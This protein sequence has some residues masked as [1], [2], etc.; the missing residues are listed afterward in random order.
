MAG[1]VKGA[2]DDLTDIASQQHER[3]ASSMPVVTIHE[4]TAPPT[5]NNE[6]A[7]DEEEATEDNDNTTNNEEAVP[8]VNSLGNTEYRL[9]AEN[10]HDSA[11]ARRSRATSRHMDRLFTACTVCYVISLMAIGG[12]V[13]ASIRYFPKVPQYNI[14]NDSVA[15]KSLVDSMTS[16]KVDADIEILM[17]IM[18]PNHFDVA[19]DM[20]RGSFSHDGAFVGTFEIPPAQVKAMSITDL[21]ILAKFTPEK[22]EALSLTAEYYRGTLALDIDS[23]ASIRVPALA[24]YSYQAKVTNMRVHVNDPTMM[25]RHLCACPQWKDDRNKTIAIE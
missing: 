1:G 6:E 25:D 3:N 16:M 2:Y 21:T 13:L 12:F 7:H 14:C 9:M 19:L 22:W 4:T 8:L 17:S 23:Q 20:G 24:N 5:A 11:P 10:G 18:N 15:W